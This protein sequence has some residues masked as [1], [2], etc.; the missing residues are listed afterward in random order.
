MKAKY[1]KMNTAGGNAFIDPVG[2]KAYVTER[3]TT[4]QK[5]WKRQ[6]EHPGS[7]AP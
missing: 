7:A 4:F 6:Q 1:E 2:Y 3:E 5:E